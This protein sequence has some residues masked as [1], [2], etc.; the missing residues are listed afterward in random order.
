MGN[1]PNQGANFQS[2]SGAND[3]EDDRRIR[4]KPILLQNARPPLHHGDVPPTL[5]AKSRAG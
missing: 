5:Y 4:A 2:Q 1:C 3:R